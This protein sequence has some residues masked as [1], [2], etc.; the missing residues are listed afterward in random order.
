[1]AYRRFRRR[2]AYYSRNQSY[3]RSHNAECAEH[4]GRLPRTRAASR[5]GVSAKA[6][7]AGCAHCGYTSTEWHHVGKYATMVDY[8]DTRELGGN[9]KFWM[10]ARSAYATKAK[11]LELFRKAS[12][13][14]RAA[15]DEEGDGPEP[16]VRMVRFPSHGSEMFLGAFRLLPVNGRFLKVLSGPGF[17]PGAIVDKSRFNDFRL[18]VWS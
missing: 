9:W 4:D 6:F 15:L 18:A 11:R 10:G 5:L 3:S 13:A 7:A 14:R 1:M 12:E 8:Y 17:P 2:S 16:A